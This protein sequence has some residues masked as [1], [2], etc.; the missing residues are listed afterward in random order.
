MPSPVGHALA[1]TAIAA[2]VTRDRSWRLAV[3]CAAAAALADID[4]LLPVRHRGPTHSIAASIVAFA[5]ASGV[6]GLRDGY[7]RRIRVAVAV[8][9][10]VLSH[11]LLDWLGQDSST[12]RGVMAFWPFSSAYHISDLS[13]FNA[14]DRRYWLD[15]FWQRN[16]IAVMREVAILLPIAWLARRLLRQP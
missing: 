8:G 3:V 14:V 13:V 7:V 16:T 9:L 12:P 10:A 15:G 6:L 4:F 2:L 11:V 1:G 5:V